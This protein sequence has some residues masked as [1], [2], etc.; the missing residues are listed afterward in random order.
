MDTQ[1]DGGSED[2]SFILK[3]DEHSQLV[4]RYTSLASKADGMRF[5]TA[6]SMFR[7]KELLNSRMLVCVWRV[8][9]S[10]DDQAPQWT[11]IQFWLPCQA[12]YQIMYL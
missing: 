9:Y 2:D 6:A 3:P 1:G 10:A 11:L 5:T 4:F 7:N 12:H 8:A